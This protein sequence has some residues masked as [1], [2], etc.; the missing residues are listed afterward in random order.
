[1]VVAAAFNNDIEYQR[2]LTEADS[3]EEVS[4]LLTNTLGVKKDHIDFLVGLG[5]IEKLRELY[6]ESIKFDLTYG[7]KTCAFISESIYKNTAKH[8]PELFVNPENAEHGVKHRA[9]LTS[10][11]VDGLTIAQRMLR[12]KGIDTEEASFF[13]F[14][15]GTGKPVLIAQHSDFGFGFKKAV[16]IDYYKEVIHK[17]NENKDLAGLGDDKKIQFA[18]DDATHFRDFNGINVAYMYNPFD[19]EIMKR[20]E[21]NLRKY[22]GN[23]LII[24]N[25]PMHSE[26]FEEKNWKTVHKGTNNDPDKCITI[27]SRGFEP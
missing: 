3:V 24:Y 25:K 22:A 4:D 16:G 5:G 1:M 21:L 11:I 18:F 12:N 15:T 10:S 17:A 26:L 13:D 9:S 27:Y 19:A 6:Y 2:I 14:G 20:V 7:T 8:H 23:T